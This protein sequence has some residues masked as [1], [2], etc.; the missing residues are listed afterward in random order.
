[1]Q[2]VPGYQTVPAFHQPAEVVHKRRK[3]EEEKINNFQP[4]FDSAQSKH[5]FDNQNKNVCAA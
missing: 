3:L 1:M 2:I 5:F 4:V